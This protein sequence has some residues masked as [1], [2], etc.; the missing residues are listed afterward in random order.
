DVDV[1]EDMVVEPDDDVVVFGGHVGGIPLFLAGTG[2]GTMISKRLMT[3]FQIT[4][5][6]ATFFGIVPFDYNVK[7]KKLAIKTSTVKKLI[8]LFALSLFLAKFT[9]TV[10]VLTKSLDNWRE[11][12]QDI[13]LA[14]FLAVIMWNNATFQVNIWKNM[15]QVCYTFNQISEFNGEN[16]FILRVH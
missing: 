10:F 11:N 12:L 6:T 14:G 2:H 7:E 9:F 5:K 15:G 16:N 1:P 4:F 8:S 13:S 3:S